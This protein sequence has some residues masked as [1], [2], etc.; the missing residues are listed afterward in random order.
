MYKNKKPRVFTP[1]G[2]RGEL[3]LAYISRERYGN[4]APEH[5]AF[6]PSTPS[7]ALKFV[8]QGGFK[9]S[10]RGRPVRS[11]HPRLRR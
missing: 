9:G 6:T 4:L 3:K 1:R 5:D 2:A 11:L 10:S 7:R 8:P